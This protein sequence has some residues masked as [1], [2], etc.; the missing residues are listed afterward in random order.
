MRFGSHAIIAWCNY[1]GVMRWK[2]LKGKK[3]KSLKTSDPK[4]EI[5]SEFFDIDLATKNC[6]HTMPINT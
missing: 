4:I 6:L 3:L 5:K 1:H 2:S